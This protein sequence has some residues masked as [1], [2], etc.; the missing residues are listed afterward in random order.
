MHRGFEPRIE[1]TDASGRHDDNTDFLPVRFAPGKA[2]RDAMF[3]HQ[4]DSRLEG[5]AD[6]VAAVALMSLAQVA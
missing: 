4:R 5:T 6:S 3:A 2:G 1:T